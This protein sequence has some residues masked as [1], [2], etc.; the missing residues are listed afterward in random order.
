MRRDAEDGASNHDFG[1]DL[2]PYLVPRVRVF[3]H[4]FVDSCVN[5]VGDVPY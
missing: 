3:A 4:R 1:R 5:M 2:I